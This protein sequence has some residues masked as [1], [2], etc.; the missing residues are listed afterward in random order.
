M[1]NTNVGYVYKKSS[2]K[3][4]KKKA[5]LMVYQEGKSVEEGNTVEVVIL[6]GKQEEEGIVLGQEQGKE[7]DIRWHNPQQGDSVPNRHLKET[8]TARNHLEHTETLEMKSPSPSKPILTSPCA[9]RA[10]LIPCIIDVVTPFEERFSSTKKAPRK[11]V[12]QASQVRKFH[13]DIDE[14]AL[15]A[16]SDEEE[17]ESHAIGKQK[18]LV[19]RA[20][21]ETCIK[22]VEIMVTSEKRKRALFWRLASRVGRY[23]SAIEQV[24]MVLGL[25]EEQERLKARLK[26]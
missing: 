11:A 25:L 3:G 17:R 2:K 14:S 20:G 13:L 7:E 8:P 4:K 24:D 26:D 19:L 23:Q 22:A 21:Y 16:D 18:A 15:K 10:G 1:D 6:K 9:T 12:V 5:N